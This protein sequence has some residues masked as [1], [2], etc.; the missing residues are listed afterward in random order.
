MKLRHIVSRLVVTLMMRPQCCAISVGSAARVIR[1]GAITLTSMTRRNSSGVASHNFPTGRPSPRS[2]P[3]ADAGIVDQNVE[4]AEALGAGAHDFR[5]AFIPGDVGDDAE[6]ALAGAA[7]SAAL[8]RLLENR[9]VELDAGDT[10][11]CSEQAKRHDAAE[12]APGPGDD[13]DLSVK[14][15]SHCDSPPTIHQRLLALFGVA[16]ETD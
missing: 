4:P 8:L 12:T 11:A 5:S 15:S 6:E 16:R 9:S 2:R 3:R 7:S 13:G 14:H 10:R 1:N